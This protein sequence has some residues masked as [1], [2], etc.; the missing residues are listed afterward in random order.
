MTPEEIWR[1]KSDVEV[2][3][4]LQEIDDYTEDGQRILRAEMERR[5]ITPEDLES[6]SWSSDIIT[7]GRL[8]SWFW[9]YLRAEHEAV[10][11]I[12][13][14]ATLAFILAALYAA[15]GAFTMLWEPSL[16]SDAFALFLNALFLGVIGL[17]IKERSQGWSAVAI[18]YCTIW[19]FSQVGMFGIPITLVF[20]NALR[21]TVALAFMARIG[22]VNETAAAGTG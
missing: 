5:G 4:A 19:M 12:R 18:L 21:A 3:E 15:G 10:R 9:S 11:A 13:A 7:E 20:V 6:P 22:E 2:V 1:E 16:G 17:R 14:A 8:R